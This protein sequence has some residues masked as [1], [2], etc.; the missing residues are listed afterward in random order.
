MSLSK[1]INLTVSGYDIKL[2]DSLNFYKNDQLKL[3]FEINEYGI[4]YENKSKQRVL[5]PIAEPMKAYLLIEN[6][7]G[8]DKI[9]SAEIESN[10]VSFY[11]SEECTQY[12]G[13]SRLQIVLLD[14]DGCKITL[15]SFDF[16]IQ[17]NIYGNLSAIEEIITD[18]GREILVTDDGS[19][20]ITGI[21]I[22]E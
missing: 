6:P 19:I 17:E 15:P 20:L 11:L 3:M 2:S 4:D 22:K 13:V 12:V 7:D 10:C 9:G 8:I 21:E 16:E 18:I 5:M 14:N 1:K